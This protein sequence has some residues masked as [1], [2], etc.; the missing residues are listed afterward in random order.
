MKRKWLSVVALALV[1][2]MLPMS[3]FAVEQAQD[4]LS[5]AVSRASSCVTK[6]EYVP[7]QDIILSNP[8]PQYESVTGDLVANVYLM[9]D[10]TVHIGLVL[11]SSEGENR[12]S[13]AY[14]CNYPVLETAKSAGSRIVFYQESGCFTV[15]I[16]GERFILEN[17][18]DVIGFSEL[19]SEDGYLITDAAAVSLRQRRSAYYYLNVGFVMNEE[20]RDGDGLCW[21]AS[22]ACKINY[23]KGG[24]LT[25]IDVYE[26]CYKES[27][28]LNRP[29]GNHTWYMRASELYLLDVK[30]ID[31]PIRDKHRIVNCLS[32]G[33]PILIN[34]WRNP[35]E[36]DDKSEVEGKIGHAVIICG[37]EEDAEFYEF[38]LM[39]PNSP[40]RKYFNISKQDF[41]N[42][43]GFSYFTGHSTYTEWRDSYY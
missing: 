14:L 2:C 20:D 25:A 43:T 21:A 9:F 36:K 27:N 18:N 7:Q 8:I 32:K 29:K 3:A 34:I 26:R 35:S 1:L 31:G 17:P 5:F 33:I 13:T 4:E 19:E 24:Q 16:D 23:Q 40:P 38:T 12:S 28:F 39:D 30:Y 41:E 37:F 6:S 22:L 11:V 42:G 15:Y 10:G